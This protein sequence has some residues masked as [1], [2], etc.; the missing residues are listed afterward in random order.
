MQ[1]NLTAQDTRDVIGR[2]G[3]FFYLAFLDE[4]RAKEATREIVKSLRRRGLHRANKD[5]SSLEE[6]V[7]LIH[8][9]SNKHIDMARPTGTSFTSGELVVPPG[10]SWSR[11]LE[12]RRHAERNDFYAV[13]LTR[14]LG[15]SEGLV[16]K[17]LQLSEGTM[18]FR[19][20]R[21]LRVLGQISHKGA[22]HA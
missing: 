4:A 21:G 12:F 17:A 14:V 10:I 11:W 15:I 3:L 1:D 6:L 16:A 19:V 22:G 8:S 20:A 7:Q 13:L 2:A 5:N 9:Y 18:R